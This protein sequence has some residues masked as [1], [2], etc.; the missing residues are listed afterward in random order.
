VLDALGWEYGGYY[1]TGPAR[2]WNDRL[3]M[4][5]G[6]Q[7]WT[8][9][10]R[11]MALAGGKKFLEKHK[12]NPNKHSERFLTD[13]GLSAKDVLLNKDG[14]LKVLSYAERKAADPAELSR[15]DRVRVALNRFVDEAILR[16][17]AAQ[18]PI[19]ASDPHWMLVFHLKAFT[20][21]FYERII[22]RVANEMYQGN[23]K[24]ALILMGYLP[25][26]FV[27]EALRNVMQGDDMDDDIGKDASFWDVT[28]YMAQ[29]SGFYGPLQFVR[30]AQEAEQYGSTWWLNPL[31]PTIQ[32]ASDFLDMDVTTGDVER[33]L[34]L[35]S[36][37]K[38]W[39][40]SLQ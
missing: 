38:D 36:L 13:L 7:S 18:R 40:W 15:D 21:S 9:A 10:T 28:D 39:E 31:G 25:A 22:K 3:F 29:K 33:S 24:P 1:V 6:L 2:K 30:D 23:Y 32:H 8:R 27:A 19:W 37:Y 5:N 17:D 35:N 34:P 26:M 4:I 11:L 12:A 16:P 20:Y 14:T